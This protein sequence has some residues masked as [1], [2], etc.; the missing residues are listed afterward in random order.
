[1]AFN[2]AG[3][4]SQLEQLPSAGRIFIAYSGGLDSTVLLHATAQ[5][6]SELTHEVHAI[7][8]DHGLQADASTWSQHCELQ[9]AALDIPLHKVHLNLQIPP[10]ESLEAVARTARYSA[11]SEVLEAGDLLLT[12]HHADDQVET[13]LLQLLRGG[14][15]SGLAG[16]PLIKPWHQCWL[17][18]PLLPFS[19]LDL[20][21]Y[22]MDKGL[23]WVEDASNQD[24]RFSRNLLRRRVIPE[25]KNR[26]PG[27]LKTISRSAAHCASSGRLADELAELDL[28]SS[29]GTNTWRLSISELK[30]L[31]QTRQENLL[32]YWIRQ[33]GLQVPNT[34]KIRR[35]LCEVLTAAEAAH[36]LVK[37]QGAELRRYGS[38]LYLM[39]PLP[40]PEQDWLTSWDGTRPLKLPAGLGELRVNT[41]QMSIPGNVWRE[42]RVQVG[43]RSSGLKCAPAGRSGS[44][45][46]KRLCQDLN[47]PAWLRPLIPLLQVDG[48][49]A[50]VAGYCMC[51]PYAEHE[52]KVVS[53]NRAEWLS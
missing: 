50:A 15:V 17:A 9:C 22:A 12:A 8:A 31:S 46:F 38:E 6:R 41:E 47:I 32:R 5:L 27:M 23:Y 20:Q 40:A 45:S 44:R 43:F 29:R 37:W 53:W 49:L 36:P 25:L 13:V 35:I 28:H 26:W 7:H 21:Q 3:L 16:M 34:H 1:M 10:G 11:F 4:L 42:G 2:R 48:E 51:R 52:T 30:N 24:V 33:S 19:R 18:R 14:G 39:P